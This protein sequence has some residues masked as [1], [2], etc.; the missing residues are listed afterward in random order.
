MGKRLHVG[1]RKDLFELTRD[2][3]GWEITDV[4]FLGDPVSAAL[5]DGDGSVWTAL[6]LGHFGAKL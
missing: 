1:T 6:D 2:N 3:G 4:S 5:A